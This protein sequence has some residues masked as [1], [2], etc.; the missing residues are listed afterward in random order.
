[1]IDKDNL[2]E[3]YL[4]VVRT[5]NKL[6]KVEEKKNHLYMASLLPC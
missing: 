5:K 4:Q 1:M 3:I 6:Y 2:R